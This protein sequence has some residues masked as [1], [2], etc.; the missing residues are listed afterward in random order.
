VRIR[1]AVSLVIDRNAVA[2]NV[3]K[4][5]AIGFWS[6]YSPATWTYAEDIFEA[7]IEELPSPDTADLEAAEALVQDYVAEEGDVTE[8]KLQVSADDPSTR[9]LATYIES[10]AD[11]V[12]IPVE[13]VTLPA[14]QS[15]AVAFDPELK[16]KYDMIVGTG[17]IDTGDPLTWAIWGLTPDGIFNDFGYDNPEVTELIDEARQTSDGDTRAELLGQVQEIAYAEDYA[18]LMISVLAER[19]YL[20]NRVAGV[21]ASLPSYLYYPWSRDLGAA[22]G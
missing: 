19:L 12:G 14:N 4:D 11:K 18:S 21:P 9:Q 17:Y 10:Q 1:E 2:E 20:G 3:F 13:V 15:L 6:Y 7:Q 8:L 5:S 16:K 22:G